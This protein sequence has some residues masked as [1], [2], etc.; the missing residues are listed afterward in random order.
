MSVLLACGL[1]YPR[2][3]R[4]FVRYSR[5]SLTILA[6]QGGGERREP[7]IRDT[8]GDEGR[9]ERVTTED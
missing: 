4:R 9:K 5:P 2:Y 7:T 6:P 1:L 8:D 3:L